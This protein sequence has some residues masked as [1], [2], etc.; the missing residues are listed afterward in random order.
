MARAANGLVAAVLAG[1]ACVSASYAAP[2]YFLVAEPPAQRLHGDSFVVPIENPDDITHARD[3]ISRG[4][5]VAGSSIVFAQIVKGADGH[6][7]DLLDPEQP[8]WSWHVSRHTD[9]GD[10]GIEL[11]DGWPTHVQQN[12]DE[13]I[14]A[15]GEVIETKRGGPATGNIGF[16]NY[17][18]V[19]ELRDYTPALPPIASIPLPGA[20]GTG[21]ITMG[22]AAM[23]WL[24]VRRKWRRS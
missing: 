24:A 22:V 19:A 17:T 6:N 21:L 3:L 14:R 2:T 20:L 23:G 7:R 4:R 5:E 8:D 11:L 16:W 13:W 10:L 18:V 15:T 9:F 1:C 12:L